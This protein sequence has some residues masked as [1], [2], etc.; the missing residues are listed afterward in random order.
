M[1]YEEKYMDEVLSDFSRGRTFLMNV[2][3]LCNLCLG[4]VSLD[5]LEL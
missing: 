3:G 1:L 5:H 4:N 2:Q